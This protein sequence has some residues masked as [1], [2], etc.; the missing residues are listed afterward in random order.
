LVITVIKIKKDHGNLIGELSL[1]V[2]ILLGIPN[3]EKNQKNLHNVDYF[4]CYSSL[5]WSCGAEG[6]VKQLHEAGY[7]NYFVPNK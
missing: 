1:Q 3:V 5:D 7:F 6:D 2:Q 4:N